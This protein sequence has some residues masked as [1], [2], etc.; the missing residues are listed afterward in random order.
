MKRERFDP[1]GG[2]T[3]D[4]ASRVCGAGWRRRSARE[5]RADLPRVAGRPLRRPEHKRS[6]GWRGPGASSRGARLAPRGISSCHDVVAQVLA[7]RRSVRL[8]QLRLAGAVAAAELV[9]RGVAD[10]LSARRWRRCRA[11]SSSTHSVVAERAAPCRAPPENFQPVPS[12]TRSNGC[13][14]ASSGSG[15]WVTVARSPVTWIAAIR[16]PSHPLRLRDTSRS[17]T[18]GRVPGSRPCHAAC[19]SLS[20]AEESARQ[21]RP[22]VL[23][24][25]A[26]R[27]IS[28][29][30]ART[31]RCA[32]AARRGCAS[33][34]RSR[35]AQRAEER[36]PRSTA[37]WYGARLARGGIPQPGANE[38]SPYGFSPVTGA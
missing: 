2:S 21:N 1:V 31:C 19:A 32:E 16:V 5:R 11:S 24:C 23:R 17:T 27:R 29:T 14:S 30:A 10:A 22:G 18:S 33:R 26:P 38:T 13:P 20:T 12:R 9:D 8:G 15:T 25:A 7:S 4:S 6:D 34:H 28:P 36:L 37:Y 3:S 35:E